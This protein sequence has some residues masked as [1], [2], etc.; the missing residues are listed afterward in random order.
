MADL[1]RRLAVVEGRII[2]A[3]RRLV[4][5]EARMAPASADVEVAPL[6]GGA[7]FEPSPEDWAD[8]HA[9]FDAADR[10]IEGD[11]P[12]PPLWGYE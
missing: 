8:Y 4:A 2:G 5:L 3:N 11:G 12:E 7:P 9:H 10:E 6:A 1:R